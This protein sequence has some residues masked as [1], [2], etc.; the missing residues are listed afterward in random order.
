MKLDHAQTILNRINRMF[1]D[2]AEGGGNASALERDLLKEYVRRLYESLSEDTMSKAVEAPVEAPK[3]K[4]VPRVAEIRRPK[5]KVEAKPEVEE[6]QP[7]APKKP[8]MIEIPAEVEADI[9][10]IQAKKAFT[11]TP[12]AVDN[13]A[14]VATPA[15]LEKIV[16]NPARSSNNAS[17][18]SEI[19]AIFEGET[20]NDLSEK[21]AGA[22]IKDLTKAMAINE[23][24]LAQNDLFGGDKSQLDATLAHLNTLDSFAE[25]TSYLGSGVATQHDW[26]EGERKATARAFAKLV[27]RRYS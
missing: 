23:R 22:P 14:T 16:T 27:R 7:Q 11:P 20:S 25:A 21:L 26:A 15:V 12:V 5:A 2:V 4:P 13:T 9:Q 6:P 10:E 19:A 3:E 24:L 1:T 18:S 17:I 8:K